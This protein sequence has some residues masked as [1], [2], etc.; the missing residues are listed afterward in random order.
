MLA[1][2]QGYNPEKYQQMAD[3]KQKPKTKVADKSNKPV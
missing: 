1:F 3:I 2:D